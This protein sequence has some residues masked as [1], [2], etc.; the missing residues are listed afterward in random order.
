ML[1]YNSVDCNFNTILNNI[2][3]KIDKVRGNVRT[4]FKLDKNEK[5][6]STQTV[7][8]TQVESE[9]SKPSEV[10]RQPTTSTTAAAEVTQSNGHSGKPGQDGRDNFAGGCLKGF[11][12]TASGTCKKEF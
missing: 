8:P 3:E 7:V 5:Q 6:A 12:R 9:A 4:F 10:T 2:H 1:K 11:K